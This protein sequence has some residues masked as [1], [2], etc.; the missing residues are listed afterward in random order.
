MQN[1]LVL[2]WNALTL[3]PT[4]AN[5]LFEPNWCDKT[6]C[7]INL[8]NGLSSCLLISGTRDSNHLLTNSQP[9]NLR[10]PASQAPNSSIEVHHA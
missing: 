9:Y 2:P 1:I 5:R 6:Q 8:A 4:H 10:K 7:I 3:N